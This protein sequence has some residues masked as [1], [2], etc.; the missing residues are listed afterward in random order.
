[1]ERVVLKETNL[2]DEAEAPS[3]DDED[4][5]LFLASCTQEDFDR[6]PALAALA[7]LIDDSE[8]WTGADA[9]PEPPEPE[10]PRRS[11]SDRQ[12]P[13]GAWRTD[14][15]RA[16]ARPKPY[17]LSEKAGASS[18]FSDKRSRRQAG[19]RRASLGEAQIMM[20]LSS[21]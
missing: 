12:S 17:D 16:R 4:H 14:S 11:A 20:S 18:P 21:L 13:V 10:P 15:R 6:C 9:D 5:P 1:M 3:G 2:Q 8:G 7:C 19:R